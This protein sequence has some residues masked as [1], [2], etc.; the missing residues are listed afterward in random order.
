MLDL[1]L[2]GKAVYEEKQNKI[3]VNIT[4]KSVP[5]GYG[6]E[7]GGIQIGKMTEELVIPEIWI[8]DVAGWVDSDSLMTCFEVIMPLKLQST[9]KALL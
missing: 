4:W 5:G 3:T 8:D 2:V 1:K 9:I 7:F 6:L